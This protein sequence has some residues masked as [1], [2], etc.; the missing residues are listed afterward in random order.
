MHKGSCLCRAVRFE[1]S[2]SLETTATDACHCKQCRKWTGHFLASVEVPRDSLL[3]NGSEY[4]SWHHSSEKVRR[5]FCSKCGSSLFF[6]PL[7]TT[8]HNWT[9]IALGSFDTP[10]ETTLGQHIFVAEKG[11]YY[12]I[13]DGL[14]QNEY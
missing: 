7:D 2:S 5:G 4:I 1:V 12:E 9:G 11:D 14:P 8:K 6:D 10:T 3:I 13:N